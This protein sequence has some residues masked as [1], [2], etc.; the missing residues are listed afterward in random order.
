MKSDRELMAAIRQHDA[1]ALTELYERYSQRVY[2]L[3][4][5]IVGENQIAQEVTQDT[6]MRVWL[7]AEQYRFEQGYLATW[8]LTIARHLAIDRWRQERRQPPRATALEQF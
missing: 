6:F 4:V 1:N 3:A 7:R 2:S 5:V 8:L